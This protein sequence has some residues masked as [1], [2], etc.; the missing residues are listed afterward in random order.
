METQC[1]SSSLQ[2]LSLVAKLVEVADDC[3]ALVEVTSAVNLGLRAFLPGRLFMVF[4]GRGPVTAEYIRWY[5][6]VVKVE[7]N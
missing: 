7:A 5:L 4:E 2:H 1:A 3:L 6:D